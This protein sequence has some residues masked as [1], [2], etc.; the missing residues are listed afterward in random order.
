[1]TFTR[2]I[3]L[4]LNIAWKQVIKLQKTQIYLVTNYEYK[5]FSYCFLFLDVMPKMP[6]SIIVNCSST[7]TGNF[8]I[9]LC[10]LEVEKYGVFSCFLT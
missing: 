3:H 9:F 8:S 6:I 7:D 4:H 1:M 5:T 2:Q 10:Y